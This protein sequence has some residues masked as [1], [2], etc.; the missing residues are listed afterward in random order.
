MFGPSPITLASRVMLGVSAFLIL[1]MSGA[2]LAQQMHAP[3]GG[4]YVNGKF[5]KGG[6]FLPNSAGYGGG[7]GGGYSGGF[8]GGLADAINAPQYQAT[9]HDATGYIPPSPRI[10]GRSKKK[11]VRPS[12]KASLGSIAV[13]GEPS[14]AGKGGSQSPDS[15]AKANSD[16]AIAKTL[17]RQGKREA[18]VDWLMDVREMGADGPSVD[19]ATKLLVSLGRKLNRSDLTELAQEDEPAPD[20]AALLL[21][22]AENLESMGK[23]SDALQAYRQLIASF[24]NSPQAKPAKQRIA[25]IQA[26]FSAATKTTG[27]R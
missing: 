27:Q 16:L 1:A 2:C 8:R 6:Q 15:V 17:I 21:A 4:T 3:A 10:G 5:Y 24:P 26:T 22:K 7:Y 14:S 20:P 23:S 12:T 25:A 19:E 9:G 13:A 11:R 18:A